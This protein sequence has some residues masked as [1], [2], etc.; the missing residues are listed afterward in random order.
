[1]TTGPKPYDGGTQPGRTRK[2]TPKGPTDMTTRKIR[3]LDK[4]PLG[5]IRISGNRN[6]LSST[7]TGDGSWTTHDGTMTT[8]RTEP[9]PDYPSFLWGLWT[10]NDGTKGTRQGDWT[11]RGWTR[12]SDTGMGTFRLYR[13][14][15][16]GTIRQGNGDIPLHLITPEG[17]DQDLTETPL[18]WTDE[19]N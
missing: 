8:Q 15:G 5:T 14:G 10:R 11:F 16:P 13:Q 2:G 6:I 18:D 9:H 7:R 3:N 12:T 19:T 4:I 17:E 1:M